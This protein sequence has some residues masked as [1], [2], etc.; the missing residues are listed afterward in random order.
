MA[1]TGPTGGFSLEF[2]SK[3]S[4]V[5]IQIVVRAEPDK[6]VSDIVQTLTEAYAQ[7]AAVV[8]DTWGSP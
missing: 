2:E 3:D 6:G 4:T 7:A 1:T 8:H 5:R